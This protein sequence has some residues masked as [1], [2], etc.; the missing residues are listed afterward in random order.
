MS[1]TIIS[2]L[3]LYFMG[4]FYYGYRVLIVGM[5]AVSTCLITDWICQLLQNKRVN[6]RDL[7]GIVTGM[8][9]SLMVPASLDLRIVVSASLFAILVAKA[10]F[11]GIGN[12]IFNPAAAG[13][14][15]VSI[16]WPAQIFLYT[17]PLTPLSFQVDAATKFLQGPAATLR[18]GGTPAVGTVE[19]LLGNFPGSIGASNIVII[20]ACLIFLIIRGCV[21]WFVPITYLLSASIL[22]FFLHSSSLTGLESVMYELA[23]NSLLF[24][25]AYMLTEPVTLPKRNV[26]R[27]LYAFTA[28]ILTMLFRYFG[29]MEQ[30]AVFVILLMNALSPLFDSLYEWAYSRERGKKLEA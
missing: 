20:L 5:A 27:F 21:K 9:I 18:L 12:N 16:S 10:P 25:A 22:P 23:S 13:L 6:T 15:F 24:V 1:D 30:S 4:F 29:T 19:L 14:A 11:G 17:E 26:G 28:G 8:V 2:L 3:P 7:S